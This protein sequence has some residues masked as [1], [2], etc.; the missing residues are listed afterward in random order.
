MFFC[1][2]HF[3]FLT[4]AFDKTPNCVFAKYYNAFYI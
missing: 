3:F 4:Y 1:L 2:S